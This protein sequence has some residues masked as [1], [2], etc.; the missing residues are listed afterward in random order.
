VRATRWRYLSDAS[1]LTMGRP[2]AGVVVGSVGGP[3]K[4]HGDGLVYLETMHAE[5]QVKANGD[6]WTIVEGR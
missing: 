4:A 3:G 2:Y 6:L 5:G 1:W